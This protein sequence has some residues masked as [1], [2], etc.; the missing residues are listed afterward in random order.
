MS[1]RSRTAAAVERRGV[2]PTLLAVAHGTRD[3]DG[4]A[5]VERLAARV[6]ALRPEQRIE[7]CSLDLVSP[8]L[9]QALARLR[10][11]VIVVPLL[12]GTGYHV[13]V[14]IPGALAAAPRVR[15]RLARPLGPHPL[16][17]DALADHLAAAGRPPGGGPVVLAAA[18]SSDPTA[19]ADAAVMASLLHRRLAAAG[20]AGPTRGRGAGGDEV[21]PAYLSM[22][23][24]TPAEAVAALRSQ[25][26]RHI[27][28]A[29]Y[30][31]GPGFFARRAASAGADVTSAPVGSHESV[32][33]LVLR[34]YD[35]ARG[36]LRPA[37]PGSAHGQGRR[38]AGAAPLRRPGEVTAPPGSGLPP[39]RIAASRR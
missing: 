26:H 34:R 38:G 1:A 39:G 9:P 21:I 32:A 4:V 10:G 35:E 6:R 37:A 36:A 28:V 3:A 8:D 12:L 17:A 2:P 20:P 33:R 22:A 5:V 19:N 29:P 14:D 16:L 11:E 25:G 18:G 13:R 30:L 24:P 27:T 15:A 7:L 31:L 23:S